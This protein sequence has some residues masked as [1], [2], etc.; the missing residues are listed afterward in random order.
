MSKPIPQTLDDL[1]NLGH[2]LMQ[3]AKKG[4]LADAQVAWA[5]LRQEAEKDPQWAARIARWL[6]AVTGDG[7]PRRPRLC[8]YYPGSKCRISSWVIDQMPE[9]DV[10][11]EPFIGLGA[12]LLN[13][14]PVALEVANDANGT[15]VA[16]LKR[17]GNADDRRALA[18]LISQWVFSPQEAMKQFVTTRVAYWNGGFEDLD[19]DQRVHA[20]LAG[21]LFNLG[22]P[23]SDKLPDWFSP[24]EMA[25]KRRAAAQWLTWLEDVGER[26]SNV[27]IYNKDWRKLKPDGWFS[28]YLKTHKIPLR[29]VLYYL[30]PPYIPASISDKLQSAYVEYTRSFGEDEW[31]E[32]ADWMIQSAKKGPRILLSGMRH[33]D[34]EAIARLDRSSAI[35]SVD[36]EYVTRSVHSSPKTEVL[37]ANYPLEQP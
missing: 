26:L 27:R 33:P 12:V 1:D 7:G 2:Q 23:F 13:K 28:S 30:D 6:E 31:M 8:L 36:R 24:D 37:W 11:V 3:K 34:S 29:R 10:Y 14:E 4:D 5:I 18:K 35:F 22:T 32:I 21:G 17:L 20:L 15:I 25:P 19:E 16:L 9:H